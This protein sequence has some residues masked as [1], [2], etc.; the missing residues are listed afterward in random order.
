MLPGRPRR[1]VQF[2]A[3]A[4]QGCSA[5]LTEKYPVNFV[6]SVKKICVLRPCA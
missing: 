1:E 4:L 2:Y 5:L 3:F 6:H